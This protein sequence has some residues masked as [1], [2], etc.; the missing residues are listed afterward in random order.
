MAAYDG[1]E[2][3]PHLHVLGD[4]M[5]IAEETLQS[6]LFVDG[7]GSAEKVGA[8]RHF[9]SHLYGVEHG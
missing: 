6:A 1:I 2:V 4:D 8:T 9:G 7:R 3:G 5:A